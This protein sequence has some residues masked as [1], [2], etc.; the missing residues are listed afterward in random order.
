MLVG[1][2]AH[3]KIT[4]IIHFI[5]DVWAMIVY[6]DQVCRLILTVTLIRGVGNRVP[7]IGRSMQTRTRLIVVPVPVDSRWQV[8]SSGWGLPW[9]GGGWVYVVT[10][11]ISA[12]EVPISQL[13]DTRAGYILSL[14]SGDLFPSRLLDCS[15]K[16]VLRFLNWFTFCFTW[17][18]PCLRNWR[19]E[20][21]KT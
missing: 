14:C 11:S 10:H 19:K 17:K 8:A 20:A 4:Q 2:T 7:L 13:A 3:F 15:C 21:T 1:Q 16:G 9:K 18:W 12:L 5:I 6:V